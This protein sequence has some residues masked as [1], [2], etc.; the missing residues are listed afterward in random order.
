MSSPAGLSNCSKELVAAIDSDLNFLLVLFSDVCAC[1]R[2][3]GDGTFFGSGC[4][5]KFPITV[6]G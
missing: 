6:V 5:I 1:T 3:A 2:A 4:A